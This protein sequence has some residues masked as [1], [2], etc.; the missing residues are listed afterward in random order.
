MT[1]IG[2]GLTDTGLLRSSNQDAFAILNDRGLWVVADG[3]GG[4]PG[5]DAASRLAVEVISQQAAAAFPRRMPK[6]A[7]RN[8]AVAQLKALIEAANRAILAT[9][10][11][12]PN[13]KGMG[14]TVVALQISSGLRARATVAHVG[15][16]RA[17]L[18][19][20]SRLLPLTRDHSLVEDYVR[21]G[22]ISPEE[23]RFHPHRHVLSRALGIAETVE[24]D[25]SSFLLRR[26]D[27]LLLCT[28][29]LTKMLTDEQIAG[30]LRRTGQQPQQICAAL[31]EQALRSGG[32]DNVTVVACRDARS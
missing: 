17:Y 25:V 26:G 30:V 23:A 7:G 11:A 27:V 16:S 4:H 29:G 3:M 24:P 19:R 5:G 31:V 18:W 14:T 20:G 21:Q 8:P 28:D 2:A 10:E 15:D 13:L 12:S 6:R 32:E 9:A 22:L 1:W